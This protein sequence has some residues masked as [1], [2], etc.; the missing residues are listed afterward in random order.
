MITSL[1]VLFCGML[2]LGGLAPTPVLAQTSKKEESFSLKH[3]KSWHIAMPS[4]ARAALEKGDYA[5]VQKALITNIKGR[6]NLPLENRQV[7]GICMV[8]EMLRCT[9]PDVLTAYAAESKSK[10]AF[11]REFL[12]DGEWLELYLGCGLVPY[13]SRVGIDVLYRIWREDK[14]KVKN[15]KLA[16]ALASV[17]GGGEIWKTPPV[18]L[19]NPNRYNPVRRYRFFCE[20]EKKGLLHKNYPNLRP[21]ELRFVVGN[22]GQDWDDASYEY[23]ARTIQIPWDKYDWA[24]WS[25]T[26]TGVSKFGDSV[27]GGYY[28][29]PF[30][31]IS[32][33]ESTLRSGGV[34]GAMSHLGA[35][36]AMAHG[37]P[38]YT[39][40]QPG[41][42][43]YAVRPERG[44]WIGGFGGPDGGM[45]NYI[46]GNKAPTSYRLMET[47]FGDDEGITRAYLKSYCARA[48]EA[49]GEK[50][51]AVDAWREALAISPLHPFFRA[52]LHRLLKEQGM[53][54]PECYDYLAH[55]MPLYQGHGVAAMEMTQDLQ[56]LIK[57]F[58]EEQRMEIFTMQHKALS[59][60]PSSWAVK[61]AD[62]VQK[63]ADMMLDF[64][65]REKFL[66][67]VFSIHMNAEDATTFGQLLEWAVKT[68]VS[69]GSAGARIF[70]NAFAAAAASGDTSAPMSEERARK[71]ASIY[72][73]AIFA[74]EEARSAA[75]F[76]A[77]TAG[78]ARL[79]SNPPEYP[80]LKEAAG[81]PGKPLPAILFRQSTT[82]PWDTPVWHSGVPTLRGGKC[83]T[84]KEA[85]PNFI[86]ELEHPTFLTGCIIR[87]TGNGGRMPRATVY[88]SSDGATWFKQAESGNVPYEWSVRF[89]EGT[90]GKWV[91]LEFDNGDSPNFAHISHFVIYGE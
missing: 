12:A 76:K 11:L 72:G 46:F 22:P 18:Q 10:A 42:C 90:S 1:R 24:C 30:S 25:A 59:T 8:L 60:T 34:C 53:S 74:A 69:T 79:G 16:V 40:G 44:K 20:Q 33:A 58:S 19:L 23:A 81:M 70:N 48:W 27:Q 61:P 87:K 28:N 2:A 35:V 64:K 56:E 41:H 32:W 45:H 36:A 17:W 39:C 80:A 4:K 78:A 55:T 91:K 5:A 86:V 84:A 38:A 51:K 14:G 6:K 63:Q 37:I 13:H 29:L 89:P 52:E 67:R 82:S 49:A 62:L 3:L 66:A 57:A 75:A 15:K 43:A 85:R 21:W 31:E 65:S 73:K 83:H 54:A 47:V 88:T 68:Y 26:Y 50:E 9:S 77:L 71:M 7:M